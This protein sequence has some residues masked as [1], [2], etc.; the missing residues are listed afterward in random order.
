MVLP[1]QNLGNFLPV[2]ISVTVPISGKP[3]AKKEAAFFCGP[4]S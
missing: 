1:Q 3:Q 4:F 2:P